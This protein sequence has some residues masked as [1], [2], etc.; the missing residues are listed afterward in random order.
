MNL[1]DTLNADNVLF[2]AAFAV[3]GGNPIVGILIAVFFYKRVS[4]R[5]VGDFGLYG[6]PARQCPQFNRSFAGFIEFGK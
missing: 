3:A 1:G 6:L 4:G 5:G 2:R